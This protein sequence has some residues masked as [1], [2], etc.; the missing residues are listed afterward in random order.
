MII[1]NLINLLK[2]IKELLKKEFKK[3]FK[4]FIIEPQ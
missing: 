2:L 4:K 3:D 1:V